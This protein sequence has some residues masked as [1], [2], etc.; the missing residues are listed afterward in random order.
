MDTSVEKLV[1]IENDAL[2]GND[3]VQNW[4]PDPIDIG[5]PIANQISYPNFRIEALELLVLPVGLQRHGE[6]F[7]AV[8][9]QARLVWLP[10]SIIR[11]SIN[12]KRV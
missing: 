8:G 7:T 12:T 10:L 6:S 9:L 4:N 5:G 1:G 11:P 3:P 2:R